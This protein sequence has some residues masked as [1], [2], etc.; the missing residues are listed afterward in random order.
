MSYNLKVIKGAIRMLT[1]AEVAKV[2]R[3]SIQAVIDAISQGKI[4]G[5]K[6]GNKMWAI[7]Q[8]RKLEEWTPMKVRQESGRARWASAPKK[9][10]VRK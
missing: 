1:T 3:C 7:K 2:K 10:A 9:K 5:E 6:F 4:D 8:N